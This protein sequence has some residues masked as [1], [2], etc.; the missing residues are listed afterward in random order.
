MADGYRI[1][2]T[3][4]PLDVPEEAVRDYFE[5]QGQVTDFY[6]PPHISGRG[7]KGIA[8]ISFAQ[9]ME[10]DDILRN[11]DAHVI[12]GCNV[13]VDMARPKGKGKGEKGPFFTTEM[14]EQTHRIFVT[15]V[16]DELT[17]EDLEQYFGQFGELDDLF[18]PLRNPCNPSDQTHKG[19]AF[20]SFKDKDS[21]D[22]VLSRDQY[23]IKPDCFIVVDKAVGKES[24]QK[25]QRD[26]YRPSGFGKG[27]GKGKKGDKGASYW[28]MMWDP[29]ALLA[30]QEWYYGH[31]G[32]SS[33][34]GRY[35]PY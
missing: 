12:N 4:I 18:V 8:F 15:R 25:S 19:I 33:S 7:H 9:E 26:D 20:V 5:G 23:E 24:Q 35:G 28:D 16:A 1:F 32:S 31:G 34:G 17:K 11:A 21:Y 29:Y 6:M 10:R 30:F 14:N 22:E 3:K 27:K 13:V 2:V